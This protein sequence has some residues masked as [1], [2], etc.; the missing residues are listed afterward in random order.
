MSKPV[1]IRLLSVAAVD[2]AAVDNYESLPVR[3]EFPGVLPLHFNHNP[4][5][6]RKEKC[7]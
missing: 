1:V 7:S 6:A 2:N 4:T 3:R 5:L